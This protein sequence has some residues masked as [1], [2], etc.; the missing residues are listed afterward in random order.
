[1]SVEPVEIGICKGCDKT[2]YG[3]EV[4]IDPEG[5]MWHPECRQTARRKTAPKRSE[6]RA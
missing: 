4:T 1:M 2:V 5:N 3:G 6:A